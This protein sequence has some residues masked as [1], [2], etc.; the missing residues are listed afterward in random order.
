M[1]FTAGVSGEAFLLVSNG[2]VQPAPGASVTIYKANSEH[3]SGR[4][5]FKDSAR[6]DKAMNEELAF[7]GKSIETM[8][9]MTEFSFCMATDNEIRQFF[10]SQGP[11]RRVVVVATADREGRFSVGLK[12]GWY[13]VI[14]K[15]QAGQQHALWM[16]DINVRWRSDVRLV[17]PYCTYRDLQ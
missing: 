8:A 6:R 12:P 7:R 15:G 10:H 1:M 14:V 16:D 4:F 9:Q 5:F 17:D 2:K 13:T 11:T 3:D